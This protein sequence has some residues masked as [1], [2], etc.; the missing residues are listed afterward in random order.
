MVGWPDRRFVDLVGIEVPIVQAP[1]AAAGGVE[2]CVA[3]M[4]GGA[5]GSL[6]CALPSPDQLRAQVAEVRSR[7]TG[8]V[9][10]NFFC[11]QMPNSG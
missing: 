4:N 5:L 3:A 1:M 11:H 7:A 8:P 9:N 6:P 10:L 2:L